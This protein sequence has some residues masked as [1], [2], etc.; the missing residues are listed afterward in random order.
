MF[1]GWIIAIDLLDEEDNTV[2]S[3]SQNELSKLTNENI[4]NYYIAKVKPGK[5]SLVGSFGS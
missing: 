5:H 1:M 3:L 2:F 4:S